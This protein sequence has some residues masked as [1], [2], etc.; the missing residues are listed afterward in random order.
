MKQH[1]CL[2]IPTKNIGE[3]E[4]MALS[5][6][7]EPGEVGAVVS[8]LAETLAISCISNPLLWHTSMRR[9]S[10]V[11]DTHVEADLLSG[12]HL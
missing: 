4:E 3:S 10:V 9:S 5:P 6:G 8:C 2:K 7:E 12:H 1:D 11:G